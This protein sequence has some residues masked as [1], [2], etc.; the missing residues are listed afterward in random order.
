[1]KPEWEWAERF[2][3]LAKKNKIVLSIHAPIAAILGHLAGDEGKRKRAFGMI[4]HSAGVAT[5]IS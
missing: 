2:G 5:N 1:M 4:D 3:E